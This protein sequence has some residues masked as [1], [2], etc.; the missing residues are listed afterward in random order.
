[1]ITKLQQEFR[2]KR[3]IIKYMLRNFF[4]KES[5]VPIGVEIK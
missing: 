2:E 1:M 5:V 3:E 4:M